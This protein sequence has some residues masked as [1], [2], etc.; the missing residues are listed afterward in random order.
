MAQEDVSEFYQKL[1]VEPVEDRLSERKLC[2]TI[3]KN[4]CG[5]TLDI[6][7]S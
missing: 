7:H 1:E 5:S 3:K 4:N 2:S 6:A